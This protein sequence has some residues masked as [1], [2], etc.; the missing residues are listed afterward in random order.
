MVLQPF[1]VKRKRRKRANKQRNIKT[2]NKTVHID[3][4]VTMWGEG[5]RG[6]T[7]KE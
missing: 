7:A 5:G 2:Y 4:R 6:K 1:L 3:K